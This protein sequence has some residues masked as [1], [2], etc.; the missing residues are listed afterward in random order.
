LLRHSSSPSNNIM[1]LNLYSDTKEKLNH[2]SYIKNINTVFQCADGTFVSEAKKMARHM[3]TCNKGNQKIIFEEGNYSPKSSIFEKL[4]EHGILVEKELRF[5]PYYIFYDFETYLKPDECTSGSKLQFTGTYELLSISLKEIE[6]E[7]P[8][9]IPVTTTTEEAL[10]M[11]MN[12]IND[13][14]KKYIQLLYP[15]Y[16]TFFKKIAEIKDEKTKIG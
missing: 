4:E 15:K 5:Y 2:F 12:A 6:E 16:S 11:M 1:N 3:L 10:D 7:K 8:V 14:R 13:I 9:F